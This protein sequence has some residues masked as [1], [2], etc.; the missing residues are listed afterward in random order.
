MYPFYPSLHILGMCSPR[1]I[2]KIFHF[3]RNIACDIKKLSY[4]C[5]VNDINKL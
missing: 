5:I 1:K 2:V 3:F 4:L